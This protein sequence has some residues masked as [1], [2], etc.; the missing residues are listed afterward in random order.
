M[1]VHNLFKSPSRPSRVEGLHTAA[2]YRP[3][4]N[5]T[6]NARLRTPRIKKHVSHSARLSQG[7]GGLIIFHMTSAP[8]NF[9]PAHSSFERETR[10]A[11]CSK[12][13]DPRIIV[14]AY[15][16]GSRSFNQWRSDSRIQT[17]INEEVIR[18]LAELA[19]SDLPTLGSQ[20]GLTRAVLG[21]LVSSDSL[22]EAD[23]RA[24]WRE[25]MRLASGSGHVRRQEKRE[26]PESPEVENTKV[27]KCL[28]R[29]PASSQP[30]IVCLADH[31]R[32]VSEVR[33]VEESTTL[34]SRLQRNQ[35]WSLCQ[36]PCVD[37]ARCARLQAA[38][39]VACGSP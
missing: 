5:E 27:T 28:P 9:A 24:N 37:Y 3:I 34:R 15:I 4:N 1:G 19:K 13:V 10:E 30:S 33:Q 20:T 2:Y 21:L 38:N 16:T 26:S 29:D 35:V 25:E 6:S 23:G 8:P 17:P 39:S 18:H 12:L 14:S 32:A 31:E 22:R 7:R 36:E 11:G